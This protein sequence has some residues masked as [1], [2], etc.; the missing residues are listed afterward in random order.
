[1][2]DKEENKN[3][4]EIS[5]LEQY[6]VGRLPQD[7]KHG[8]EVDDQTESNDQGYTADETAFANGQG[9]QLDNEFSESDDDEADQLNK[10]AEGSFEGQAFGEEEDH[11]PEVNDL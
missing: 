7:E 3:A 11:Q 8:E 5:N 2:E 6:H 4:E 1:M 9:T 10:K